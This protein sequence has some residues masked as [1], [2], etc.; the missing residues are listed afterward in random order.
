MPIFSI[1]VICL[2][3]LLMLIGSLMLLVSAFRQSIVWGLVVIF[4]PCG[5][6]IYTCLHWS[7]AR[8]SFFTG[9]VG[10]GIFLLGVFTLPEVRAQI[11]DGTFWQEDSKKVEDLSAQIADE[12]KHIEELQ[13][14][15]AGFARDLPGEYQQLE[16]RRTSLKPGDDAAIAKFNEDAAAYQVK[17]KRHKEIQQELSTA[18]TELDRLLEKRARAAADK[19]RSGGKTSASAGSKPVIM[20]T[21]SHCPACKM[22]KQYMAQKSIPYQE[23]DVEASRDGMEAFQRLGGHGVPLIMVGDKKMEGFNSQELDRLLL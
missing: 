12:R 22:A 15:F 18:Q 17:N 20:Y 14:A 8:T 2:G 6:L 19:A 7:R 1:V 3:V 13:T 10:T 16:K 9:L 11:A 23:I 5:N 21:T 4:A